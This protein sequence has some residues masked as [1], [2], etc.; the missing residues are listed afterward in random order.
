MSYMRNAS[1]FTDIFPGYIGHENGSVRRIETDFGQQHFLIVG[2]PGHA[3]GHPLEDLIHASSMRENACTIHARRTPLDEKISRLERTKRAGRRGLLIAPLNLRGEIEA[4]QITRPWLRAGYLDTDLILSN[5]RD[6][7]VLALT[8]QV[9][10]SVRCDEPVRPDMLEHRETLRP[11]ILEQLHSPSPAPYEPSLT[12]LIDVNDAD[13][14]EVAFDGDAATTGVLLFSIQQTLM[15]YAQRRDRLSS[16]HTHFG[17]KPDLTALTDEEY[18]CLS[19]IVTLHSDLTDWQTFDLP[20]IEHSGFYRDLPHALLTMLNF[21]RTRSALQQAAQV[22][23]VPTHAAGEAT[24]GLARYSALIKPIPIHVADPAHLPD[25]ELRHYAQRRILTRT[26]L[27]GPILKP[28]DLNQP[29]FTLHKPFGRDPWPARLRAHLRARSRRSLT[30]PDTFARAA[31][32]ELQHLR[33]LPSD[34]FLST[35]EARSIGADLCVIPHLHAQTMTRPPAQ[36][37]PLDRSAPPLPNP[38]RQFRAAQ[39]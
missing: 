29:W 35:N 36:G 15:A 3:A 1:P 10:F 16:Q 13:H 32:Q 26:G 18:A 4:L 38:A 9:L 31:E 19:R 33:G 7:E 20:W 21:A 27:R 30:H 2:L 14:I 12:P 28:F 25:E 23:Y 11:H 39:T 5:E 34:V 8:A 22:L 37:E 24:F 17:Q 6:E